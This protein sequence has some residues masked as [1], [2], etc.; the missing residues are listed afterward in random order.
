M[1]GSPHAED[2]FVWGIHCTESPHVPGSWH[3]VVEF[4]AVKEMIDLLARGWVTGEELQH[5][6]DAFAQRFH[7]AEEPGS[8]F[9]DGLVAEEC[10][11]TCPV[12]AGARAEFDAIAIESFAHKVRLSDPDRYPYAAGKNTLH[13]SHC[14]KVVRFVG[15]AESVEAPWSLAGLPAFAHHGVFSTSWA[16]G[17][18]VM[19]LEEATEWIGRK[20]AP[21]LGTGYK[22]CRYCLPPVL[23]SER[24]TNGE[25]FVDPG[26][27]NGESPATWG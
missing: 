25:G 22:N 18:Q 15:R 12:C 21:H 1:I 26:Y 23:E 17:M 9:E 3:L 24:G 5:A 6:L 8:A 16:A 4:P 2:W 11:H 27:W 13:R 10:P 20:T 19:T 14:P 7:T